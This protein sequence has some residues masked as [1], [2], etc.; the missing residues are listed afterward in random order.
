MKLRKSR[1][2]RE[3]RNNQ[4][5]TCAKINLGDPRVVELC[6]I[7]GFST[8][9]I[10]QEH[11]PNDWNVIENCVR[12]AKVHD[13][14]VIV[15]APRGS[16][17]DYIRPLECDATGLMIPHVTSAAEARE[18]VSF[19]RFQPQGCRPLDSG[20][21]DGAFCQVPLMEYL[22]HANHE[23]FLILQIE[24]PQGLENVEEIAAVPGFDFLLFGAG[25]FAH[26][27]GKAGQ[28]NSPEVEA[29]RRRVEKAALAHGKQCMS[30]GLQL[31]AE[32]LLQRGYTIV[33]TAS[34]VL[35][36]SAYFNQ[37]A[38]IEQEAAAPKSET[39]YSLTSDVERDPALISS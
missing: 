9:W 29:A 20:N 32:E 38:S 37:L 8:V 21:V 26:S 34:D 2:L 18:I 36:L 33:N 35:G 30:V 10:C 7:A 5:A 15:R 27:I 1:V 6:G 11:V 12:A 39:L 17:S 31:S 19:C 14:D 13:M 16:Y 25:D 24:C 22:H 28:Y 23:R 3:T 4:V